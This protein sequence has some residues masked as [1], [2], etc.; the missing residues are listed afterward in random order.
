MKLASGV[1][2]GIA[3]AA[4]ISVLA[5]A[6]LLPPEAMANPEAKAALESC[7]AE[8]LDAARDERAACTKGCADRFVVAMT[9]VTFCGKR[10]GL[11]TTEVECPRDTTWPCSSVFDDDLT[12]LAGSRLDR[13]L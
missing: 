10:Y 9:Y 11:E 2:I 7:T 13:S 8:C 3:V 5:A 6:C 12:P 1:P 4:L